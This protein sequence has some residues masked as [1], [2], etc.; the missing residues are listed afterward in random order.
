MPFRVPRGDLEQFVKDFDSLP[1]RGYSVTIP[2]KEVA[3]NLAERKDTA[4]ELTQ[5]ALDFSL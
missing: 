3:A 1:V 2:H 4:V 5:A